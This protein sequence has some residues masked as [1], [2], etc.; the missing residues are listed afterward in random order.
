MFG[1][2]SGLPLHTRARTHICV[3]AEQGAVP[4]LGF[5]ISKALGCFGTA[6]IVVLFYKRQTSKELGMR[7]RASF[8]TVLKWGL[9]FVTFMWSTCV[10]KLWSFQPLHCQLLVLS[11]QRDT[12][13]SLLIPLYHTPQNNIMCRIVQWLQTT[14]G[15]C[16]CV[17]SAWKVL[18]LGVWYSSDVWYTDFPEVRML[19]WQC[20][21]TKT[22]VI[23]QIEC[24]KCLRDYHLTGII[25]YPTTVTA[26]L[27][28]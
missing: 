16:V 18:P 21:I 26:S 14:A 5:H 4:L 23:T 12:P 19:V 20:D 11:L 13:H 28:D 7:S 3:P 15:D 27:W 2:D 25:N 6:G 22:S 10:E 8:D 1:S 17:R 9:G 24:S